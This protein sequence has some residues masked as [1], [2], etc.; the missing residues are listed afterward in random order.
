MMTLYCKF[1]GGSL[2]G[3]TQP[4]EYGQ[5]LL[6]TQRPDGMQEFYVKTGELE[7]T[8]S[9]QCDSKLVEAAGKWFMLNMSKTH[10]S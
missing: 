6:P 8:V 5:E 4:V 7:Y 2:D 3:L 9:T 10:D 1:I